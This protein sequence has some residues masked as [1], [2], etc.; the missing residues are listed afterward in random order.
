V[1]DG[2]ALRDANA[3]DQGGA[4]GGERGLHFHRFNHYQRLASLD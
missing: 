3:L 1:I 4:L 2:L